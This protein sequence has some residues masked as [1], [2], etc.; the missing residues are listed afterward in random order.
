MS[1]LD[2]LIR[3][4]YRVDFLKLLREWIQTRH[5]PNAKELP[6]AIVQQTG[7]RERQLTDKVPTLDS[8]QVAD[9]W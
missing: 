8:L 1:S 7:A 9:A 5:P 6:D 2:Y 3:H 4:A